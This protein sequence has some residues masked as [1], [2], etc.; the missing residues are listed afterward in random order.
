[1]HWFDFHWLVM[2]V[3]HKEHAMMHPM[4]F[5]AVI[6]IGGILVGLV[7]FRLSRHSMVPQG[8]PRLHHSLAFR[9][10]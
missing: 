9:N 3:L 4:D 10:A 6:G 5:T 2:P 8:D 7:M 1:M